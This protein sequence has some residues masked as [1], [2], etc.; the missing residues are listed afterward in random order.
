LRE[1]QLDDDSLKAFH[2]IYGMINHEV[3]KIQ[4][5]DLKANMSGDSNDLTLQ[6]TLMKLQ[7]SKLIKLN[8]DPEVKFS[9][10]KLTLK[11]VEFALE[12]GLCDFYTAGRLCESFDS[13]EGFQKALFFYRESGRTATGSG[14]GIASVNAE[15]TLREKCRARGIQI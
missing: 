4:L 3:K 9:T 10:L 2:V 1:I 8:I 15:S 11:G 5:S 13:E 6:T 12:S 14:E 7:M